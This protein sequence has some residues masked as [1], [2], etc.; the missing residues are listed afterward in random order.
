MLNLRISQPVSLR[1]VRPVP[2]S[3]PSTPVQPNDASRSEPIPLSSLSLDHDPLLHANPIFGQPSLHHQRLPTP[4]QDEAEPMDWEPAASASQTN[5]SWPTRPLDWSPDERDDVMFG[6]PQKSDWDRFAVQK[7]R[8]FPK[9]TGNEET[10]LESLLAGWGIGQVNDSG[11]GGITEHAADIGRA[12][13]EGIILVIDTR[14][15]V[16]FTFVLLGLVR[17]GLAISVLTS[18]EANTAMSKLDR[19]HAISTFELATAILALPSAYQCP[20]RLVHILGASI[21]RVTFMLIMTITNTQTI[22]PVSTLAQLW[23]MWGALDL[24]CAY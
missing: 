5:S 4:P 22:H 6:T 1:L 21:S 11:K 14:N 9:Q 18:G 12:K 7:Q 24:L 20:L 19:H 8:M 3:V 16:R 10:G 2:L 23:C 15:I 13:P 17:L